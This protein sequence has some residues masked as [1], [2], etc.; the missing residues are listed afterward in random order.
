MML[1]G[2]AGLLVP[3]IPGIPLIYLG[4][5]IFGLGTHWAYFGPDP[6]I[7]WG[8]IT[9]ISFFVDNFATV[10][11]AKKMGAAQSTSWVASLAGLVGFV[12]FNF[13]GLIILPFAIAVV[14]E[15]FRGKTFQQAL[16]AGVG[17]FLG[18]I[19]G[20]MFKVFLGILMIGS[21]IWMVVF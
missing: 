14:F 15:L 12:F 1:I 9:L 3:A 5:L 2:V 21:F 16:S 7:W 6:L 19:A 17:T 10:W 18:L 13:V 8:I 20:T 4:M 11:G